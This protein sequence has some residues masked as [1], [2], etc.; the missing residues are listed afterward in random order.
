MTRLYCIYSGKISFIYK[1]LCDNQVKFIC[2]VFFH[3]THD[4][5]AALLKVILLYNALVLYH[6]AGFRAGCLCRYNP[7]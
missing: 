7:V 2:I 6:S 4:F 5:K 3:N 1:E